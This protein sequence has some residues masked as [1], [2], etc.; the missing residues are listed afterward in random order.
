MGCRC[1][2]QRTT[3]RS[4]FSFHLDFRGSNSGCQ[5]STFFSQ[6]I[7]PTSFY[8]LVVP[9]LEPM[10]LDILGKC[11]ITEPHCHSD[12][13][14]DSGSCTPR[15]L[16]PFAS[17]LSPCTDYLGFIVVVFVFCFLHFSSTSVLVLPNAQSSL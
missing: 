1:Q 15:A 7:L 2:R 9:G 12:A 16:T 5:A 10:T 4:Q 3:F 8:F 14:L 6:G 17:Q 13:Q 11:S